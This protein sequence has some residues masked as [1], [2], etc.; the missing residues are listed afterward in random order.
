MTMVMAIVN[1][2]MIVVAD[3]SMSPGTELWLTFTADSEIQSLTVPPSVIQVGYVDV[4]KS[5]HVDDWH[6]Q[7]ENA[8][9]GGIV[10][11]SYSVKHINFGLESK[12]LKLIKTDMDKNLFSVETY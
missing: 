10:N 11:S 6:Y 9:L 1:I 3:A 12:N 2:T 5:H 8:R 7:I 4:I